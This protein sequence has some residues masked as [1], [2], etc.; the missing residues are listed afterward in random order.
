MAVTPAYCTEK[1]ER[2]VQQTKPRIYVTSW[3]AGP[4]TVN[5]VFDNDMIIGAF[6]RDDPRDVLEYW[7]PYSRPSEIVAGFY[8]CGNSLSITRRPHNPVRSSTSMELDAQS[9]SAAGRSAY[10]S[11]LYSSR[12]QPHSRTSFTSNFNFTSSSSFTPNHI[13]P[14][15]VIVCQCRVH[16]SEASAHDGAS[17]GSAILLAPMSAPMRLHLS[18]S[19]NQIVR[20]VQIDTLRFIS[21]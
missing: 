10:L 8:G 2:P 16:T 9:D 11:D 12:R 13:T 20:S 7:H 1:K 18:R 6:H 19:L 17:H 21:R 3:L 5:T 14:S 4:S 15:P